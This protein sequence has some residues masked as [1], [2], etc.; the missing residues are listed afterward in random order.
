M[1]KRQGVET[2]AQTTTTTPITPLDLRE[3]LE[4]A[5]TAM[6]ALGELIK[7][8]R[9]SDFANPVIG[10]EGEA[11]SRDIQYGLGKIIE[12]CLDDQ[13]R[14]VDRYAEQ[15]LDS[16]EYLLERAESIFSMAQ[17][18]A[19]DI[20]RTWQALSEAMQLAE[21]VGSRGGILADRAKVLECRILGHDFYQQRHPAK[22]GSKTPAS[23]AAPLT[24]REGEL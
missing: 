16:D 22:N 18:S 11:Y 8:A 2:T 4:D 3:I 17:H 10:S 1:S 14:I 7:T 20:E 24:V 23:Q 5:S 13:K 9:L 6:R 15:Y 12:L 21:T 19:F